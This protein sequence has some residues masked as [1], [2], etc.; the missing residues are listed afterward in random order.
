MP[1]T[2]GKIPIGGYQLKVKICKKDEVLSEGNLAE[3]CRHT[4]EIH[5]CESISSHQKRRVL[6]HECFHA[7]IA[8]TGQNE[9]LLTIGERYEESL[10]LAFEYMLGHFFVF[11]DK[12]EKWIND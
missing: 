8:L 6:A 1:V 7:F 2:I 3:F 4:L 9:I 12:I 10:T 5:I 11:P